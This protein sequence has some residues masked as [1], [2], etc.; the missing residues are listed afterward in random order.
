MLHEPPTSSQMR[1][2]YLILGM[3]R[4][5]TSGLS[6]IL[7]KLGISPPQTLMR[8]DPGNEKGYFESVPLMHLHD[9]ILAS[10]GTR[11]DDWRLFH[12]EWYET[13]SASALRE[14]AV[15][16]LK[17]EFS[18]SA[19]FFLKDPRVC[20]FAPFW[21][22]IFQEQNVTPR[23]VIP[24]RSPL[25]VALSL[26]KRDDFSINQGLLLWLSITVAYLL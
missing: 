20:R 17:S 23:I 16:I 10:A 5:G 12:P 21:L 13:A 4:S 3:H 6:G 25:E 18:D 8:A 14:K 7:S 2:G 1:D 11:W 19:A 22:S 9:E 24:F 15:A 26:R